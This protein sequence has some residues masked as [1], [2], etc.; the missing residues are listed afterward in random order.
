M[1]TS[2][3]VGVGIGGGLAFTGFEVGWYILAISI[4]IIAGS[5]MIRLAHRRAAHR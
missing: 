1:Y 2:P 4:L 5:L 3:T